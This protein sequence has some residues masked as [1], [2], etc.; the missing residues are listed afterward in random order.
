M[1]KKTNPRRVPVTMADLNRA[2]AQARDEGTEAALVII[3]SVLRDKEN[4]ENEDLKRV[5]DEVN[6]LS[7]SVIKGY[8]TIPDL[9]NVLKQEAGITFS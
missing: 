5:Y 2:K 6:D 8:T 4:A 3:F 9:K 1:G 7:D